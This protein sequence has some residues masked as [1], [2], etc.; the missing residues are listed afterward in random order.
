ML[1]AVHLD[2]WISHER[3]GH[4][5]GVRGI[6]VQAEL[7]YERRRLEGVAP[8]ADIV[9]GPAPGVAVEGLPAVEALHFLVAAAVHN[10]HAADEAVV[11]LGHADITRMRAPGL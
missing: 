7:L 2:G 10:L 1:R 4:L 11:L 9:A 3:D 6:A 5:Q 8:V